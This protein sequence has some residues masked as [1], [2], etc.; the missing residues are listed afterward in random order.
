M[1]ET[2]A[3]AAPGG[4]AFVAALV[5]SVVVLGLAGY[6]TTHVASEWWRSDR[7]RWEW[8]LGS[9]G[10]LAVAAVAVLVLGVAVALYQG[11]VALGRQALQA[12]SFPYAHRVAPSDIRADNARIVDL[13]HASVLQPA[14]RTD[15][16][17]LPGYRA[18]WF[19][20][21]NGQTAFA[22]VTDTRRVVYV[23]LAGGRVL[24]LSVDRPVAFLQRLRA[25]AR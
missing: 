15:G 23:P 22:I 14:V 12:S 1:G 10:T 5:V 18:G 25:W 7:L 9:L 24:L 6:V 19:R 17:G 8:V 4:P 20:L 21:E 3:I 16:L 13:Y 2:F 11:E